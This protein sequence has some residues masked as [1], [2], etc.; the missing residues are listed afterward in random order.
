MLKGPY[1]AEITIKTL[2]LILRLPHRLN[3]LSCVMNIQGFDAGKFGRLGFWQSLSVKKG[4]VYGYKQETYRSKGRRRDDRQVLACGAVAT[5]IPKDLYFWGARSYLQLAHDAMEGLV[6][7]RFW[8]QGER[9]TFRWSRPRASS[10][11]LGTT[12]RNLVCYSAA[13]WL[14]GFETSSPHPVYISGLR[15]SNILARFS[16]GW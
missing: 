16:M 15:P 5:E 2:G 3:P 7:F 10:P 1:W 8:S 11:E 13:R 6:N 9:E 14:E 12:S 4:E